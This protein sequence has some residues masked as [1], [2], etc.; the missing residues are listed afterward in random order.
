M[1]T[2]DKPLVVAHVSTDVSADSII[3]CFTEHVM[4]V[5]RPTWKR[6][7]IKTT[8][9]GLDGGYSNH[10][11]GITQ[12][13]AEGDVILMRIYSDVHSLFF[14]RDVEIKVMHLLYKAGMNPPVYC[15]FS[16][17]ICYGYAPGR[18]LTLDD[19]KNEKVLE[20]IAITM[21]QYHSIDCKD[22]RGLS[23][24]DK[25]SSL[26][27]Q[28]VPDDEITRAINDIIGSKEALEQEL[29]DVKRLL[30]GFWLS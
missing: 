3:D 22:L 30:E 1:D 14:D 27:P 18:Q 5:A 4:P 15:K 7:K 11:V 19:L 8:T 9:K 29:A 2:S 12:D 20:S 24:I 21:A 16:N 17:A 6:E 26:L 10:I 13:G 28:A 25:V 23:W